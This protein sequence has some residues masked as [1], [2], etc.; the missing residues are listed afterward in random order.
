MET[1][2]FEEQIMSKEKYPSIFPRLMVASGF[3][4]L[5]LFFAARVVLKIGDYHSGILQFKMKNI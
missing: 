2:T 1:R 4:V 5:Q 3:I